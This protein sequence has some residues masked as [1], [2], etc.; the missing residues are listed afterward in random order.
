MLNT[1]RDKRHVHPSNLWARRSKQYLCGVLH[2]VLQRKYQRLYLP[3]FWG[4]SFPT[5]L[6]FGADDICNNE[7]N[8]LISSFQLSCRFIFHSQIS[9]M[10][11]VLH[12]FLKTWLGPFHLWKLNQIYESSLHH[13]NSLEVHMQQKYADWINSNLRVKEAWES[14]Y[15]RQYLCCNIYSNFIEH[16]Q[17][18]TNFLLRCHDENPQKIIQIWNCREN[19]THFSSGQP[20]QTRHGSYEYHSQSIGTHLYLCNC[21]QI[22]LAS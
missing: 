2:E 17:D 1:C 22:A 4:L 12:H 15:S 16:L 13:M 10:T 19:S 8:Y 6:P 7:E 5:I 18:Q 3:A 11:A 20:K 21:P 9:W 14:N